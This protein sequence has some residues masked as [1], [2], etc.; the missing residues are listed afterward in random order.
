MRKF[1]CK[2]EQKL[3]VFFTA[4]L[5]MILYF[6]I[7]FVTCS[8]IEKTSSWNYNPQCPTEDAASACENDCISIQVDCIYKFHG[9]QD[10]IRQCSRDYASCT[11]SCPCYPGC[12]NGCP[13]TYESHYCQTCE[14]QFEKEHIVCK[15]LNKSTLNSCL[16]NC[17]FDETCENECFAFYHFNA[18]VCIDYNFFT[19]IFF[20]QNCPCMDHCKN[21]CPCQDFDCDLALNVTDPVYG[22]ESIGILETEGSLPVFT[23]LIR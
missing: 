22:L 14:K 12:Y 6:F 19:I 9:D 4:K 2:Y 11:D 8:T 1:R 20:I 17:I 13:C 3:L 21:G 23:K 10:C 18:K 16:D 15:N 7:P 5:N